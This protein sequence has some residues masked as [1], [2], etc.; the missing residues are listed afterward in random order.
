MKDVAAQLLHGHTT[1][2]PLLANLASCLLVIPA[3]T[4]DCERGFSALKRI[5]TSTRNRLSS[6]TL[7]DLM[8]IDLEGK[9]VSKFDFKAVINAWASIK[10]RQLFN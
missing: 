2:F 4:A 7:D 10:K 1:V 5:K 8:I 6:G 9:D 3:S